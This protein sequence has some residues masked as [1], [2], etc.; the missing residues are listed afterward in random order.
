LN[1]SGENIEFALDCAGEK[2]VQVHVNDNN[3]IEQQNAVPTEGNF[4]FTNFRNLLNRIGYSGFLTLELGW[5]YSFDPDPV[6]KKALSIS[7]SLFES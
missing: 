1:L 4:D 3:S 7:R 6:L 2:L 5:P